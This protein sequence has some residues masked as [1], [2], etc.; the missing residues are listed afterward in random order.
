MEHYD[1]IFAGAGLASLMTVHR[2]AV[3]GHFSGKQVLLLDADDK[4]INDRTWCFWEKEHGGWDAIV[5]KQWEKTLFGGTD[6]KKS[7][8][9]SPYRYKMIRGI[10]F[11]NYVFEHLRGY[12]DIVFKT[13]RITGFQEGGGTVTVTTTEKSYTCNKLLNSL[14]DPGAAQSN[15]KY[16]LLQ[17]HFTGWHIK[18][19]RPAFNDREATFMDFS[20][21]QKGNTRFMYVLPFA[22]DEALVE[23]TLFSEHLLPE[24]AYGEAIT[25]YLSERGIYNFEILH[26]EKGSIPMTVYPFW[27]HNTK[28]I[29]NIGSAGGWTKASTGFTFMNTVKQ[30]A[31]LVQFLREKEDFRMFGKK[32]RFWYYDLLLLDILYRTNEKGAGIFSAMFRRGNAALI[33]K[34]LDE[35]TTFAEDIRVILQCPKMLFIKAL[36]KRALGHK[37]HGR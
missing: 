8:D 13:E 31:R 24:A 17:Q 36:L 11:Y 22:P 14:Y 29:I 21:A 2:M 27:E 25:A 20:I 3:S 33:L 34:F 1:Y 12:N 23:Y 5:S 10:D 9:F 16:P 32:N 26:K 6:Y 35:E 7:L 19:D 18:T 15:H 37:P 30:S 4:K 28:N